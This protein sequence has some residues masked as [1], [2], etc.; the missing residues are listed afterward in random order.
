[1]GVIGFRGVFYGPVCF[2][3]I[4]KQTNLGHLIDSWKV[5]ADSIIEIYSK[6]FFLLPEE[7]TSWG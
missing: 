4:C 7:S 3:R 1:M 2:V 5:T 6:D